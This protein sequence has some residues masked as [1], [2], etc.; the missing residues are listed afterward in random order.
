MKSGDRI[1]YVSSTL[2][3]STLFWCAALQ[4]APAVHL[5]FSSTFLSYMTT[6][7][8][9][10]V[11][12]GSIFQQHGHHLYVAVDRCEAQSSA[13]VLSAGI[14]WWSIR[15]N[16]MK[17]HSMHPERKRKIRARRASIKLAG[18]LM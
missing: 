12:V 1:N 2:F 8:V 17:F 13:A 10:S 9:D 7:R 6:H 15:H 5:P 4:V 18:E 11:D 14:E 16:D 3:Y